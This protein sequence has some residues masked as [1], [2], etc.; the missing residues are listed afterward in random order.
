MCVKGDNAAVYSC[1]P[2]NLKG[3]LLLKSMTLHAE[4]TSRARHRVSPRLCRAAR[5]GALRGSLPKGFSP[6]GGS[7]G[8]GFASSPQSGRAPQRRRS[9]VL[10]GTGRHGPGGGTGGHSPA[11]RRPRSRPEGRPFPAE[12]KLR[13]CPPPRL[14]ER[15]RTSP[16]PPGP[17]PT[18]AGR[19]RAGCAAPVLALSLPVLHQAG[20]VLP[21]ELPPPGPVRVVGGTHQVE[22][23]L[24]QKDR[25]P[26]HSLHPCCSNF[27][28]AAFAAS[29]FLPEHRST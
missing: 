1:A 11:R 6:P 18:P 25:V 27:P 5:G 4:N 13:V 20:A 21:A 17:G 19:S 26:V 28:R 8:Q 3:D 10:A 16:A 7:T 22:R 2:G 12:K 14:S 23:R 29:L 24:Q 9:S 15:S